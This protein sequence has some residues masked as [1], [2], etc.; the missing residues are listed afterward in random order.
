MSL[1]LTYEFPSDT[2]SF[3]YYLPIAAHS[4]TGVVIHWGDSSSDNVADGQ[5][6]INTLSHSYSFTTVPLTVVIEVSGNGIT[7][8]N[9]SSNLHSQYLTS[10]NSFGEI[11]LTNLYSAFIDCYNLKTVPNTLPTTSTITNMGSMFAGTTMF[12]GAN[13]S[14]WNVTYQTTNMNGMFTSASAFDA[15]LSNW[16][17]SGV[18][19]M[20]VMFSGASSFQGTNID[21]W[22]VTSTTTNMNNMFD[23]ATVFNGVLSSWNI[24]GATGS[25]NNMF[26]GAKGM[27]VDN[28]NT[29]LRGWVGKGYTS[30][31]F[32]ASGLIYSSIAKIARSSFS[33]SDVGDLL[34]DLSH[35]IPA[36]SG[37][38]NATFNTI[39]QGGTYSI[40]FDT[41][42]PQPNTSTTSSTVVFE[43]LTF[44]TPPY[45]SEVNDITVKIRDGSGNIV[46]DGVLKEADLNTLCFNEGTKI[47]YLNKQMADEYIKIEMLR[48]GDFVKTFKHGYRKIDMIGRNILI[49][50]PN[51]YSKCMYKMEKTETNGLI[52]DL[53]VTGGHSILVDHM[54][55]EERELNEELFWGPTPKLDKKY[56]LLAS[57]SKQFYPM[58]NKKPYVYY[59]LV[60]D[61]EDEDDMRYGIWANGILTE[62]PSKEYFKKQKFILL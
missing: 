3:T 39:P 18:T 48:A 42:T 23:Y 10:C 26:A 45:Y 58:K 6:S 47:L 27:T 52:E 5:I 44:N 54:T 61:N 57:V 16:D 55:E 32:S 49:N 43:G 35:P 19:N 8:L 62:T 41:G 14:N 56:L 30:T 53:I 13:I 34:I 4:A 36:N 20:G 24:S 1:S 60:L 40:Q 22:I 50:N 46:F 15:D 31:T 33:S 2:L 25:M 11:G 17:F 28:Y 37:P 51:I 12:V 59:H 9:N 29:T 7:T 21:A 38:F